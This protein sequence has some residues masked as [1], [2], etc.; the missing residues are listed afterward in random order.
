MGLYTHVKQNTIDSYKNKSEPYRQRLIEFNRQPTITRVEHPTNIAR[1]RTLGYRAKQG[2]LVVRVRVI[3]GSSKRKTVSGGR[4]P[5][6]SGRY[7]TRHKSM[8]AIA[9]GRAARK[10]S[11]CE[12]LNSYFVGKSGS[13]SFFEVIL[14]ERNNPAVIS[15][16]IYSK[17]ISSKGRAMRGITSAGKAHRGIK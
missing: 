8:I 6:K 16:K 5:S 4:K 17:I 9:E 10:F 11:N 12:V 15:D 14:L 2:V 13:N 3:G 1:A 7:F